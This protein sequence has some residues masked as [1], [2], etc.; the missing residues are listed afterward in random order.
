M[1][2]EEGQEAGRECLLRS[3]LIDSA[4]KLNQI[5]ISQKG[6]SEGNAS[7]S[8]FVRAASAD[9]DTSSSSSYLANQMKSNLVQIVLSDK[10]ISIFL[11]SEILQI[12]YAL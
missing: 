3:G 11:Q 9:Q 10:V 4:E 5:G 8:N 6:A 12:F 1:L 7:H 2:T